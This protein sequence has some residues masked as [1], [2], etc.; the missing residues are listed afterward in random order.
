MQSMR[1][2][3]F[4]S[5]CMLIIIL[6]SFFHQEVLSFSPSFSIQ[7]IFDG[8]YDYNVNIDNTKNNN[9]SKKSEDQSDCDMPLFDT[10]SDITTVNYYSNGR[11]LNATLWLS[12]PLKDPGQNLISR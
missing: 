5:L 4:L 10:P 3:V 2:Y 6:F 1:E 12:S 7:Q 9:I 11:N 8:M